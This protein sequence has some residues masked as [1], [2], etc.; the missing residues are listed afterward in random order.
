M[1]TA[2]VVNF[3]NHLLTSRAVESVLADQPGAQVIVV[4]NSVKMVESQA[5]Q[6]SLPSGV[7]LLLSSEN[8][9]FGRACNLA[10]SH[11]VHDYVLLLNP[12]AYVLSGCIDS[13]E[14]FLQQTP[15]AGAVAPLVYW[16]KAATW[17]LPPAQ[18][19]TPVTELA[20]AIALR[21]RR[22]GYLLSRWFRRWAL[23]C[24]F[25]IKTVEQK[26]LSGGH[27]LL[28][29]SAIVASGGLFDPDFFMYYEDTDLCQR[30][31]KNGY[32]LYLLPTAGAVHEWRAAQNK[33]QLS[34]ISHQNYFQKHYSQSWLLAL[35]KK[36]VQLLPD[37]V[38]PECHN[39]GICPKSPDFFLPVLPPG[40]LIVEL[41]P[42]PLFVPALYHLTTG[43]EFHISKEL[44]ERLETGDYW[45]RISTHS[46][47]LIQSYHW[48]I[49]RGP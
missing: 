12:D 6:K 27:M 46:G 22:S 38:Y 14:N 5:L 34:E 4:D 29:K 8:I 42:H 23:R 1:I 7:T 28:R 15:Q 19:P 44:W 32:S 33:N 11:A 13:L 35:R 20:M 36:I 41:S 3:Y 31:Q 45:V 18:L 43:A 17:L 30:L 2:I 37:T 26:M 40:R 25:S 16:D 48:R 10:I 24:I 9:G 47:K 21:W 39:F 49:E